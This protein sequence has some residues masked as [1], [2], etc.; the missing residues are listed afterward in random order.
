M[1]Y[2]PDTKLVLVGTN[3]SNKDKNQVREAPAHSRSL[4]TDTENIT[5]TFGTTP[6]MNMSQTTQRHA[7]E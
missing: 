3:I 7:D 1:F 5:A 4:Q 2:E 6:N